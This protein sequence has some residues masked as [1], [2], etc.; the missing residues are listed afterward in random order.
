MELMGERETSAGGGI[1]ELT[2][3]HGKFPKRS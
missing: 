2:A 3:K 1:W